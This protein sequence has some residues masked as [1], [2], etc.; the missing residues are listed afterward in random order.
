[1]TTP[2]N[3][4]IV[5]L[6]YGST[7]CEMLRD[8]PGSR[9]AAVVDVNAERARSIGEAYDVPWFTSQDGLLER[10]D[11][12][13]VAVYTPSGLHLPLALDIVRAGK[14]VLLTKPMEV[15]VER[16]DEIIEAAEASGV[17][18]FSEFYLRYFADNLRTKR[19]ID[20]GLLGDMILG[21][22]GFKCYRPLAYFDSDGAWRRTVELN[23]GG[24]VMNQAIHAIDQLTWLM[25]EPETVHA[26]VG[27]FDL[28][29]PVENTAV[30]TFTMRSGA[31]ATLATTSTFR[32][33]SGVD[34]MYGGGFTTRAE[35]NGSRGSVSLI[36]NELAMEK[37]AE[38]FLPDLGEA[39][40]NVFDDITRALN[41]PDYSSPAISRG[42]QGRLV[43][44]VAK[45]IY[46]S[47]RTGQVVPLERFRSVEKIG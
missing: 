21:E 35:V 37:L 8:T 18:L 14:H 29:L 28:D 25:G 45:A 46:E 3:Y 9:L 13:V 24:I 11:V 40:R 22:F 4:A 39:P 44:E 23:G 15:N 47:G 5:G 20:A 7:R 16:A 10:D 26:H 6:G 27:T 43:I 34:D 12:D 32:T 31:I 41:D 33:T 42:R 30:A 17:Q 2:T 38:G 1:M 36:D 19:A